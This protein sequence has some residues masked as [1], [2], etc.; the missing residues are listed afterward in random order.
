[1]NFLT[2]GARLSL[3]R[4]LDEEDGV[5]LPMSMMAFMALFLLA[6]SVFAVSEQIRQRM[7]IQNAADTAAYS[8]SVVQADTLSR[9][10][11]LN[12]A[13]S[14]TYT[15]QLKTEMEYIILVWLDLTIQ[16]YN[17][18]LEDAK[19]RYESSWCDSPFSQ[20]GGTYGIGYA[21]WLPMGV[22]WTWLAEDYF[23]QQ[24]F[25][26]LIE[27]N[28]V[29]VMMD[30]VLNAVDEGRIKYGNNYQTA[31]DLIT[32]D[33]GRINGLNSA[34]ATLA[35]DMNGRVAAAA[36]ESLKRNLDPAT[37]CSYHLIHGGD[38]P[39]FEAY[40]EEHDRN[41]L[42]QARRTYRNSRTHEADELGPGHDTW[43]LFERDGDEHMQRRYQVGLDDILVSRFWSYGVYYGVLDYTTCYPLPGA[44]IGD[45]PHEK[46]T[47]VRA[48]DSRIY[49]ELFYNS[50]VAKPL[51]LSAPFFK[52]GQG[53]IVVGV[54]R[55]VTNPLGFL[56]PGDVAGPNSFVTPMEPPNRSMWA[57]AAARAGY[58]DLGRPIPDGSFSSYDDDSGFYNSTMESWVVPMNI[59]NAS[60][61]V[62]DTDDL[63]AGQAS[64]NTDMQHHGNLINSDWDATMLPLARAFSGTDNDAWQGDSAAAVMSTMASGTW[65]SVHGGAAQAPGGYDT[66][67]PPLSPA[68][69][70]FDPAGLALEH[71]LH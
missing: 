21:P 66:S 10:A 46:E 30:Q 36:E 69:G 19:D 63:V 14:W 17:E 56:F 9:M 60:G 65:R 70:N 18:D 39:Y 6:V 20:S 50:S 48:D 71:L 11:A 35:Q 62:R 1:M 22:W 24:P 37:G 4:L 12:R 43:Y 45:I 29:P 64:P 26:D 58:K 57:V 34:L 5:I 31:R 53:S 59:W 54:N 42:L 8:A 55:A 13:L 67:A 68:S 15:Q 28:R 7:E 3:R 2:V 44:S 51:R 25:S 47:E 61:Q 41:F 16:D 52:E 27:I 40:G 38:E 33:R 49:D 23:Q 32:D